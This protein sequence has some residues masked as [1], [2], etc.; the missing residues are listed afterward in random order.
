MQKPLFPGQK[1]STR[2]TLEQV[3]CLT[4]V[5]RVEVYWNCSTSTPRSIAEIAQII[6]R[7]ASATTYHV[8]ELLRVGL[9]MV[10]GERKKRSRVE[11]LYVIAARPGFVT[12]G[13]DAL[14]EYREKVLESYACLLR[15]MLRERQAY[16]MR[17][18]DQPGLLSFSTYRRYQVRVSEERSL[19]FKERT[20]N[21]LREFAAEPSDPD[22][23]NMSISF[24]MSP[25]LGE[26]KPPRKKRSD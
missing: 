1:P 22:G 16:N 17:S 13:L 25:S 12:G 9:L 15:L 18:Q 4:S 21:L 2:M 3:G 7:S 10:V 5:A 8:N 24:F 19:E 11:K 23:M 14:P 6:N 26:M 20:T